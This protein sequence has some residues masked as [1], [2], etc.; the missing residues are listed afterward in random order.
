LRGTRD[1]SKQYA[2]QLLLDGIKELNI[3]KIDGALQAFFPSFSTL[4]LIGVISLAVQLLVNAV[5]EP[6]FPSGLIAIWIVL[7]VILFVYPLYG[8]VIERAPLKAYLAILSGPLFI[9]W[10]SWVAFR[11]R[12]GSQPV[13][14]VRTAHGQ[15]K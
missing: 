1:S 11:S 2:V 3:A 4:T 5:Y 8:L 9:I 10:R 14:W 13:T 6:F 7:V 15:N 12:Y